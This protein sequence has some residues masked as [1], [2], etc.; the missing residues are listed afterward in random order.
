MDW[1]PLP[2]S[3]N[4]PPLRQ[5][6]AALNDEDGEEDETWK[7]FNRAPTVFGRA[8]DG[9]SGGFEATG[10]ERLLE[11]WGLGEGSFGAGAPSGSTKV[12]GSS[13]GWMEGW[14]GGGEKKEKGTRRG[15]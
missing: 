13:K 8:S 1:T 6:P 5:R 3:S 14:F 7:L 4:A 12:G 11:G 9:K 10:L 2:S 15:N